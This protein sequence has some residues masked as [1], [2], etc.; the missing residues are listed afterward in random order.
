MAHI[1][2]EFSESGLFGSVNPADEGIDEKASIASFRENLEN[3]LTDAYPNDTIEVIHSINDVHSVDGR[4]DHEECP[5]IGALINKV[6]ESWQWEV[7]DY[8][9]ID[10]IN[11]ED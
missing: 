10:R 2:V 8:D 7:Y 5:W 1:K 3:A 9:E 11:N 4:T 6:W